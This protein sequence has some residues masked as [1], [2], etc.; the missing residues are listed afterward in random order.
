MM[1]FKKIFYACIMGGIIF[2]SFG[3]NLRNNRAYLENRIGTEMSRVYP[4]NRLEDLFEQ[5]PGGFKIKQYFTAGDDLFKV[6]MIATSKGEPI[7]GTVSKIGDNGS[8]KIFETNFQYQDG[9]YQFANESDAAYWPYR[10]FLFE[11]LTLNR[12]ILSKLD[13]QEKSYN[14]MNGDFELRYKVTNEIINSFLELGD[15]DSLSVSLGGSNS[16]RG[17]YYSIM[18]KNDDGLLFIET[19]SD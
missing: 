17:Y 8:E 18:V 3:C 5:F 9:K 10:G 6:E 15:S 16:N 1:K 13:L 11:K 14:M 12:E 19:V 4:T 7:S 2:M